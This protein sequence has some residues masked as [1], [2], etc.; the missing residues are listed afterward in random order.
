MWSHH[1]MTN[2]WEKNGN[3][4]RLFPLGSKIATDSDCNLEIKRHLLLGKKAMANLHSV[5][6][7]QRYL[8]ANNG[9]YS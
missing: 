7:K 4:D 5:L 2:R 1:F 6:K 9:L 3:S 8:F